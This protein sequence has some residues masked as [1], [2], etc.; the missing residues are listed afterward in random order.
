M[1]KIYQGA[2]VRTASSIN[3]DTTKRKCRVKLEGEGFYLDYKEE[4][5]YAINWNGKRSGENQYDLLGYNEMRQV[6][7]GKVTFDEDN[8]RFYGVWHLK[9]GTDRGTWAIELAEADFKDT[10][11]RKPRVP[12]DKGPL[13][14]ARGVVLDTRDACSDY[15][16]RT[17]TVEGLNRLTTGCLERNGVCPSH[18]DS[19]PCMYPAIE[20]N[21]RDASVVLLLEEAYAHRLAL[22]MEPDADTG[23][24][25]CSWDRGRYS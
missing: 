11:A 18:L 2:T 19:E 25:A 12:K 6:A 5:L 22:L 20:D 23:T 16:E 4:F 17:H 9:D 3:D 24:Q 15:V 10:N 1:A 13:I 21:K 14:T 7:T 8:N